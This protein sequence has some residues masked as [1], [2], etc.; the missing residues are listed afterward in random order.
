MTTC[1][2]L[3]ICADRLRPIRNLFA[4]FKWGH[5][6]F[7]PC[8]G[9]HSFC[10]HFV[11]QILIVVFHLQH[12][13]IKALSSHMLRIF[14]LG[15]EHA[16][17]CLDSRVISWRLL[18]MLKSLFR[19]LCI[20]QHNQAVRTKVCWGTECSNI[21]RYY[22]SKRYH[23]GV[24]TVTS[25][26]SR[27]WSLSYCSQ[28]DQLGWCL[29]TAIKN[30]WWRFKVAWPSPLSC[31]CFEGNGGGGENCLGVSWNRQHILALTKAQHLR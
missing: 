31:E 19:L 6:W 25:L 14:K 11:F 13:A 7:V 5:G 17:K 12:V 8:L 4:N 16:F 24:R 2:H 29:P 3:C 26:N 15:L 10:A 28:L 23:A 22:S 27:S 20:Q 18:S 30:G 1:G 21:C 9:A